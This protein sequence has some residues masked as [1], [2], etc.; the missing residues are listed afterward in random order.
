MARHPNA[1]TGTLV[2]DATVRAAARG[3]Y[4][5][6]ETIVGAFSGAVWAAAS[7]VGSDSVPTRA[8]CRITWLR[9]LDHLERLDA[10]SLGAWLISTARREAWRQARLDGGR[11]RG[12]RSATA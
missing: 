2:S 11:G 7:C 1:G 3:E 5:A 9:C 4:A 12:A 8:A 10:D 6:W